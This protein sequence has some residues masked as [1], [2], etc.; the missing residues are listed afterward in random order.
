MNGKKFNLIV[1]LVLISFIGLYGG[2]VSMLKQKKSSQEEVVIYGNPHLAWG[3]AIPTR[4]K[5]FW[6]EK[7][8]PMIGKHHHDLIIPLTVNHSSWSLGAQPGEFSIRALYKNEGEGK[9]KVHIVSM[10]ATDERVLTEAN[11][12]FDGQTGIA[13]KPDRMPWFDHTAIATTTGKNQTVAAMRLFQEPLYAEFNQT[14]P[15]TV[16]YCHCMAGKSRSL[17]ET[18]AFIYFYPDKNR[19][20]DFSAAGW[21]KI[22]LADDLKKQLQD[23]PSFTEIVEFVKSRRPQVKSLSEMDGD[24]AGFLGLLTLGKAADDLAVIQQRELSRLYKDAQNI[25]L[26][27]KAPLDFGYRDAADRKAQE[28]AFAKIYPAYKQRKLDLLMAMIVPINEI[29]PKDYQ[30]NEEAFYDRFI[31]LSASEQARLT[32]LMQGLAANGCD[33]QPLKSPLNYALIAITQ[34]EKL[35]AGDQ[36]ELLRAFGPMADLNYKSATNKIIHG[37]KVDRYHATI[38]LQELAKIV[39][40]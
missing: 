26:M 36:V 39:Q 8:A 24:Q 21:T 29:D 30:E 2:I 12:M 32:I 16:F 13:V 7:V 3:D 9:R 5:V 15:N 40:K 4:V 25:G 20:F 10:L 11:K 22:A 27:L 34:L 37:T 18:L 31:K 33:L 23:Y 19:L 28:I 6:K 17:I 35:T 38:Q 1:V 14:P